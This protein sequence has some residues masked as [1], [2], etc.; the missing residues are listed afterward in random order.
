MSNAM[1]VVPLNDLRD[2]S[3]SVDCWCKPSEDDEC[4]GLWLHHSMDRREEY[5][6]GKMKS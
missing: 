2:H 5:E 6:N 4:P 1:H 3:A